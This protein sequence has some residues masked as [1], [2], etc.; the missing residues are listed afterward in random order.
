MTTLIHRLWI[1]QNGVNCVSIDFLDN[2]SASK[3]YLWAHDEK[4]P[5]QDLS[6]VKT[7]P[8]DKKTT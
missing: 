8:L 5:E 4:I 7:F 3:Y 6:N 1:D 2:L